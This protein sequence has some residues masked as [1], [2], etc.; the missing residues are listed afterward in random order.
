MVQSTSKFH[1]KIDKASWHLIGKTGAAVRIVLG[2][3]E[4]RWEGD[5]INASSARE[6]CSVPKK[7]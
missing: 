4:S 6:V 3:R 7:V 5:F 2:G 1:E